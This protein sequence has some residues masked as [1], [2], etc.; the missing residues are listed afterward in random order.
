[1]RGKQSY[2]YIYKSVNTYAHVHT[3]THTHTHTLTHT[4]THTPTHLTALIV[5]AHSH[6]SPLHQ[7]WQP[8]LHCQVLVALH[9][10]QLYTIHACAIFDM[11]NTYIHTGNI[12]VVPVG[13]LSQY[14]CTCTVEY[15]T[16]S[17][18]MQLS[19]TCTC[20]AAS[21]GSHIIGQAR[22]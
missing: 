7:S 8:L 22:G 9:V 5:Q 17:L 10:N 19:I 11:L 20:R 14:T 15:A 21:E 16:R 1:M 18:Y 6:G 3:H 13:E 2:M 4:H 12:H